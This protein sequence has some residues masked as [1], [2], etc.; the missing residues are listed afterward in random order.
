MKKRI[1]SLFTSLLIV[2]SLTVTMPLSI[3]T[4]AAITVF[5]Q[6]D[7][8]WAG[9]YYGYSDT[10]CTQ[11]ATISTGGC[12]ILSYVNAVYYL[13]GSFIEPTFLADWSVKNGYRV[14]GVG[15]SL[16]LYKAFANSCGGTYGI[17]YNGSSSSY[18][19]LRNHLQ[20][21][22][23]AIGSAPGHLMAIVDYDSSTGKFL[24]LDSYKSSNRY[25][26]T[27]GYTWQTES[28]CKST[29]KLQFSDFQFIK[30]N[31]KPLPGKSTIS[32]KTGTSYKSTIFN[33]TSSS[34]TNVY[35]IKIWKNGTCFK[36]NTTAGTSWSVVLPEGTYEA[37]VDS[38]NDAGY[39][40]SNTVKFTIEKGNP[41]PG[42]TTVSVAVGTNYTPTQISW[43]KTANTDEYD[44]KIWKGTAQKGEAYKILWGEKGTSCLVNLPS[45]YYEAYVDSRNSYECSM[46]TNIIKFTITDGK[47]LDI[48]DDFYASL[49]IYK[50]W[51]NVTNVDGSISVQKSE[52]ASARQ[53]W[54]F[55]RQS[56]GSYLIKN[57]ADGS[58]LDSCSPNGGL[59][60][61]KKYSGSNTQKWY[62]FGRWSGEYYFKPK[63]VNIVL[64]VNGNITAG[65]KVQVC[66]LNYSDS[67]KFAIYKLDSYILPSKVN[68][69]SNSA[70]IEVGTTKSLTAT[71]SPTNSTNKTIVWSTSDSSIATVNGGTV[72]GKKA[73]TVTITAKTTNGLTAN[74]QIKV[75][76]GHTFGSWSIT[77]SATCT[78]TGSQ[79]R[80]CS[81]CGKTETQ[82]I[83]KTGH[84]AVIDKAVTVTCTTEGSHCSVCGAV[85]KAQT[86]IS[87]TGHKSSDWII[88]KPATEVTAGSKHKECTVCKTVLETENI[89][90]TGMNIELCDIALTSTSQFFRGTRIKPVITVKNGVETLKIGT[91][92]KAVYSNNL[93]VG[94]ATVTII[95]IGKYTGSVTK[96]YDIIQ[97]SINNCDVM[98]DSDI[99]SFNGTRIKPSV[100]VYCNGTEMYNGNYTVTYS[101]N[102]SAGTA[103]I[104]L[105]G[106][107]NLKGTVTKTFKINPRNIANCTV[108]LT[109]NSANKYQP[110][111]A[112]KIGSNTIYN[113]NYTVKYV[114]SSDKK[115][116]KVTLTGK[117]NLAGTVTKT[118]TVA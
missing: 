43:L 95:G 110:N 16:G 83:D 107:R 111:V 105:T 50:N 89:P 90:A 17:T 49:L 92:Y 13:N 118:Y 82:S 93:S 59:A 26:Y 18:S 78:E 63:S 66:D 98:L 57:C 2:F 54:F 30:S 7:S 56:D 114:T 15:T 112:V 91:D 39:T 9:H 104:T 100:K 31:S 81:V 117:G 33:W 27:N 32:V 80:T 40:C 21:G 87:A 3:V 53:I 58:Y 10:E 94:T 35:S 67:Q 45:G 4:N 51:L 11:H 46:S 42:N 19:T 37:Y 48:G 6:T 44:V 52:N 22:D 113:G 103:T 72:T 23:V 1:V 68:L 60:Q 76:A 69:N 101:N 116:V 41:V 24:I 61:S 5:S 108:E 14:N 20:A 12:G 29:P 62:I 71:I 84:K 70:T 8:R 102:L 86:K 55:D 36:E 75:V 28:S 115:T 106:K 97:R 34:N 88:D 38:C 47:Y 99:Y 109:K 73:G 65:D 79:K 64:D 85:I 25:T 96:T 74:A 77:K